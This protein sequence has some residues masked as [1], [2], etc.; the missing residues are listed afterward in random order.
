VRL[1]FLLPCLLPI[2]LLALALGMPK[3][4]TGTQSFSLPNR[5]AGLE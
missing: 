1:I 3:K 5:H 2:S 4:G